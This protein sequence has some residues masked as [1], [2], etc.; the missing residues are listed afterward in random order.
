VFQNTE[1]RVPVGH[2]S[3]AKFEFI[4]TAGRKR[5]D[6]ATQL[7]SRP[8]TVGFENFEYG[9]PDRR[10]NEAGYQQTRS[11]DGNAEQLARFLGWFSIGLGI[12]EIV[13]PRQLAEMIGVENKP[14]V[15]RLMGVR[16]IGSGIAILS[17]EQPAGA[18]WSRVAGDMLDLALLGSQLD[19][20]NP[21]RQKTLAATMSVLGVTA[22][23]LYTAKSLSQQ[24]NWGR[25]RSRV[26]GGRR[27][28][29]DMVE[30]GSGIKVKT[31]VTI[32]R[33]IGEVYGFWRNF[34]NL[35]RFM[36]HLLSVEVD[37][38]RSHWTAVGPAN[39]QVEWDAETVEDRPEELISWRSLPGGQVDTAGYV[40]FRQAPG[41]RGTEVVVEMR[42]DPP[43][44]VVGA[45]IAKLF[46]ESG[47]EVVTRDL[48]AF[49]NVLETGEVVHSDSSIY[50]RAHP[51]RPPE[52]KELEKSRLMNTE[53]AV[54]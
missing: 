40:R 6:M 23:D 1:T 19:S 28:P 22:V 50:T 4:T 16:E 26:N 53:G 27:S 20:D 9:E 49:K 41:N 15:F 29:R 12:A 45:S 52:E 17:Q 46:G 33:P 48:Q 24:S 18:V 31:A 51:A 8:E 37:G 5:F 32:G 36:S 2:T 44:G 39:M 47:Q 3:R 34:E 43:G 21:E 10:Q 38:R 54:R 13:A 30:S 11:Q 25:S 42:Y 14:G 7:E 35:P